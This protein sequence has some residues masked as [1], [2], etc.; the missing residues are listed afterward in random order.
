MPSFIPPWLANSWHLLQASRW[1]VKHFRDWSQVGEAVGNE[2]NL[3]GSVLARVSKS[4]EAFTVCL[5]YKKI[6]KKI[7]WALW[8]FVQDYT[9]KLLRSITP[10]LY[11]PSLR[12]LGR[13]WGFPEQMKGL[14]I[15]LCFSL[16]HKWFT[17]LSLIKN[18]L[19]CLMI[20]PKEVTGS[21][22]PNI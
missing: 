5:P 10:S 4:L 18:G 12:I 15:K 16:N 14:I 22:T 20:V 19:L 1:K 21:V 7:E 8:A 2:A 6:F 9:E 3:W 17:H 13:V 11:M